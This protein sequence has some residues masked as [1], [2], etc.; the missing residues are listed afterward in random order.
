MTDITDTVTAILESAARLLPTP[1]YVNGDDY[2]DW[3]IRASP[4][5]LRALAELARDEGGHQLADRLDR[6]SHPLC[7]EPLD[8]ILSIETMPVKWCVN[9]VELEGAPCELHT[10][11]HASD[12]GRCTWA[13]PDA[14]RICRNAP[15]PGDDRCA[16]HAAFCRVIR[17]DG[18]VCNRHRCSVPKHRRAP[19]S[20]VR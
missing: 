16:V 15:A 3:H 19:V 6:F 1:G 4:R 8:T 9:P 11:E 14:A 12:L 20:A 13:G 10:P 18:A 2:S 7:M 17:V 5:L